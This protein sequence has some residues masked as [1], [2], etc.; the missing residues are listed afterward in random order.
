[1]PCSSAELLFWS[2]CVAL[3][4]GPA[5]LGGAPESPWLPQS[6]FSVVSNCSTK[7]PSRLGPLQPKKGI[8][9]LLKPH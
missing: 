1:M 8:I 2:L 7:D 9:S 6:G 4:L 3:M 5:Q